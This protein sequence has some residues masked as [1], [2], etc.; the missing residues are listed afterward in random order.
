[1]QKRLIFCK[2]CFEL[3]R[4]RSTSNEPIIDEDFIKIMNE[5]KNKDALNEAY[6]LGI[7]TSD[8]KKCFLQAEN[9]VALLCGNN[10]F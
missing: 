6:N 8:V 2:K 5:A 7:G 1:M 4:F 10:W 9:P 3:E